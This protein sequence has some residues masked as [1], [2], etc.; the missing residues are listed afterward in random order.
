MDSN[1]IDLMKT[2]EH[3]FEIAKQATE[4]LFRDENAQKQTALTLQFFMDDYLINGRQ[5]PIRQWLLARFEQYPEVWFNERDKIDT[6]EMIISTV[7]SL[8]QNQVAIETH[9]NKGKTLANFLNHKVKEVADEHHVNPEVF[10][11]EINATLN[12]ANNT[13]LSL[14]TAQTVELPHNHEISDVALS[15]EI[16]E[17]AKFNANLNLGLYGLRIIGTRLWN[18]IQGQENLSRTEELTKIIRSAVDSVES[19]GLQVA[20]SG[21]MVVSARKGWIKNIFDTV[22]SIENTIEKANAV[23]DRVQDVVL[24]VGDGLNDVRI[25]DK[26]EQGLLLSIDAS[27]EKAKFAVAQIATKLEKGAENFLK[28]KGAAL[29]SKVGA[30]LGGLFTPAGAVLGSAIGGFIGE[31]VGELINDKIAKPLIKTGK[32]VA[33]KAIDVVKNVAKKAVSKGKE[34][35]KSGL[36]WVKSKARSLFA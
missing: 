13:H 6:A 7:E 22:E 36:D 8:V 12:R 9:L 34:I 5:Q 19:K 18:V 1:I 24:M 26:V 27:A 21:G 14:Y 11:Q 15:R 32:K 3:Q 16:V 25:L 29:G 10:Q 35:I 23:L 17:K 4:M 30:L 20:L 28:T 33:N 31:K 2:D